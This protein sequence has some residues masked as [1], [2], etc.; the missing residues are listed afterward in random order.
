MQSLRDRNRTKHTRLKIGFSVGFLILLIFLAPVIFPKLSSGFRGAFSPLWK[1]E[2]NIGANMHTF[3]SGFKTRRALDKENTEL[4][5]KLAEQ[6]VKLVDRNALAGEN[7]ALKELL[8]RKEKSNLVLSTIL[9]KPGRSIYDTIIIDLGSNAGIAVGANVYAYESVPVGTVTSVTANTATVTLFSTA[10]QKTNGRLE[11]KNID[12]ELLGRGGGN[13]ELKVPRDV[14]LE[15]GM[16][17]LLPSIK[18]AVIA[19]VPKSITDPRDPVQTFL[20]TSPVNINE[21]NWVE[22]AH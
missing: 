20:L 15:P 10:G 5:N 6:E 18:P 21:L 16:S 9:V 2:N 14:T 1:L 8:G 19:V 13:F 4:K 11:S 3:F 7:E 17:I 12:V 22:V